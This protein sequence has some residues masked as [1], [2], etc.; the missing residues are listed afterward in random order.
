MKIQETVF[1]GLRGVELSTDSWRMIVITQCGPRIAFLGRMGSDANILY[2]DKDA[3]SR[4]EWR[5]YGGHRVWLTRPGADES[6]DT[7]AGDNEVCQVEYEKHGLIVCAPPHAFTKLARGMRIR[8]VGDNSFEVV[9]FIRNE[10]DLVYS[11]GVWSPT[12]IN[13]S[14]REIRIPLG[15]E[16]TLWDIVKIVIP[17]KF[18]GNT[19][20]I[21]D[22]Q[23][24]F[25]GDE[26]VVK[27]EGVLT[28]RCVSAPK[29]KIIMDWPEEGICFTKESTYIR[30]GRYP[31]DGC[32][33]AVFVGDK[34]WMGEMETFGVEQSIRPGETVE[35]REMW[36]LA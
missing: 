12:C 22:P 18:A 24:S 14:G 8:V 28:K 20:L 1:D 27:P 23:V 32:N 4:G 30:D 9:N 10:S 5:L 17:R 6:E 29:G 34:N 35:N 33:I 21:D 11:G 7:Y 26:L 15:E 36:I 13:P 19:V 2:W 3:V 25:R 16:N 31:L